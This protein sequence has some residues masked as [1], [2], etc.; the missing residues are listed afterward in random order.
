MRIRI[1]PI[2]LLVL[3][4]ANCTKL[5]ID[6]QD[7]SNEDRMTLLI[8]DDPL[9]WNSMATQSIELDTLHMG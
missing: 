1:L 9:I 6:P 7:L 3:V 2:A 4:F 5:D 8:I